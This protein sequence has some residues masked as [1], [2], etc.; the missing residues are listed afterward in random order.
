MF[1]VI[2]EDVFVWLW[3]EDS[4]RKFRFFAKLGHWIQD[5]AAHKA[6][7]HCKGD[8]GC[9]LCVLCRNLFSQASEVVDEDGS[10]TPQCNAKK[11]AELDFATHEDLEEA[12]TRL[13]MLRA[14]PACDKDDLNCEKKPLASPGLPIVCSQIQRWGHTWMCQNK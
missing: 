2:L 9:K 6:T 12:V 7:F 13:E 10:G 4:G 3:L 1:G 14:S 5:G 8:A 11:Y